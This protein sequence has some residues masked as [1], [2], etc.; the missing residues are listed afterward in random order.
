MAKFTLKIQSATNKNKIINKPTPANIERIPSP[1]PTK[2]QKE[3]NQISKYFKNIKLDNNTKQ[4]QKSYA[5]AL[6]QNISM[7]E[8]I[9]IKKTFPT[10]GANK[11][12]QIN[13][14]V[15]DNTKAK[16]HIQMIMKG[17]SRKHVIILM[18]SKNNMKFM[19][20]FSIHVANMNKS[21][22]NAKSEVLMD[23]IWSDPLEIMVVT[24][25]VSL[26]SDLQIIEQY[27]KN[28]DNIDALQVEVPWLLQSKSYL[29]II[30]I[31]YFPHNNSQDQLTSSDVKEI[32]KQNQIFDNITLTSRPCVIKVSLKSDMSIIWIDIWDIQSGSRAKSLINWCFS[33]E[34]YIATIREANMNPRV[35]QCKNCWKWE[36]TTFSC[37]I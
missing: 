35:P 22:R 21:L 23:F 32:I 1:I 12:E 16:S 18:S 6:K 13:N 9:K 14:I 2:F 26:Q 5:Q 27:V 29:K 30:G 24:N 34:R 31:L 17:P 10:I 36:H 11:I 25:K 19:K 15:K 8:V 28:A 20:N 7:S 33:V 37:R 3:V 4:P